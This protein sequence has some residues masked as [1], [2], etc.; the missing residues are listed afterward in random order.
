MAETDNRSLAESISAMVAKLDQ[1]CAELRKE[2]EKTEEELRKSEEDLLEAAL[3]MY[4]LS[5]EASSRADALIASFAR[6]LAA[7]SS[8][9]DVNELSLGLRAV[10]IS[11]AQA[12]ELNPQRY[13][14][15]FKEYI[16]DWTLDKFGAAGG[17][18]V[19]TVRGCQVC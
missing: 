13:K 12:H 5:K 10:V 14:S 18:E 7:A 16:S 1:K 19:R 6:S 8:V 3:K 11:R 15:A 17:E 2:Q 4:H 9:K